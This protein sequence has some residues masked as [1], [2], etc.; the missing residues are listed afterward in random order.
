MA[1]VV[2]VNVIVGINPIQIAAP[3]VPELIMTVPVKHVAPVVSVDGF[4]VRG[5][6]VIGTAFLQRHGFAGVTHPAGKIGLERMGVLVPDD[7]GVLC[8]V[9]AAFAKSNVIVAVDVVGIV[10]AA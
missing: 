7:V 8:V 1:A 2:T 4:G 9:H 6:P 5:G 10:I 3:A